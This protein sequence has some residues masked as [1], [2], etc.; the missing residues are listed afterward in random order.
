MRCLFFVLLFTASAFA[1]A[2]SSDKWL[3]TWKLNTQKSKYQSGA[4]PKSRT[5]TFQQSPGG[6]KAVSD[7]LDDVGS[8]HIEFT[9]KYDG[10]DVPMRGPFQGNTIA[11][12]RTDATTFDTIQK[13]SG[14]IVLTT[15]F[16]VSRDGQTL[17]GTSS[18]VDPDGVKFTN[19][20]VYDRAAR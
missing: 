14:S 1:Q 2:P 19:I 5:L 8:V 10:K 20:A 11:L 13:N 12:M 15:R 7:L 18:G 4:L 17:T 16:V 6:I 3:G 9:A